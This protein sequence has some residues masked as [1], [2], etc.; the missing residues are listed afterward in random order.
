MSLAGGKLIQDCGFDFDLI[1]RLRG[2]DGDDSK[3]LLH[4]WITK[5]SMSATQCFEAGV[6]ALA[7]H[8]SHQYQFCVLDII[9]IF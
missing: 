9:R 5:N 4:W 2:L 6:R 3:L 8:T 7:N 1:Q